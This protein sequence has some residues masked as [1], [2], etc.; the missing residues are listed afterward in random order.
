MKTLRSTFLVITLIA[1]GFSPANAQ[2]LIYV[3]VEP[4]RVA[5]TRDSSMGIVRAGTNRNFRVTG[6]AEDL[7]DQGGRVE[8][9]NPKGEESPAAVAAYIIAVPPENS[10]GNG[11]LAAY[12]SDQPV[13]EAGSGSTVNFRKDQVVGNTTIATICSGDECPSDG[14]LAVLA[15]VSDQH[16]VIDVQGYFYSQKAAPGYAVVELPF[17]GVNRRSITV[18]ARCPSGKNVLSGGA[19]LVNSSWIMDGTYPSPDRAGWRASFKTPG[20]TFSVAGTVWAICAT[21]Q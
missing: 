1:W 10:S 9:T 12:P 8:C 6:S 16:V 3:A 13:P 4:C 17:A 14:E 5:D 15:R 21:L 20:D 19:N 7:A 2:D 18:E 11:V